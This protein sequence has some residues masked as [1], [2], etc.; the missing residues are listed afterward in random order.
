M[1]LTTLLVHKQSMPVK[2]LIPL[3]LSICWTSFNYQATLKLGGSAS[4]KSTSTF[5]LDK[6]D[7]PYITAYANHV[8]FHLN[9]H[10]GH[11]Q[12]FMVYIRVT[13][14]LANKTSLTTEPPILPKWSVRSWP[15]M[16]GG[17]WLN[18]TTTQQ[19]Y[20]IV[21]QKRRLF[22]ITENSKYQPFAAKVLGDG[23]TNIVG[24]F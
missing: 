8:S 18:T 20:L 2:P 21:K 11:T 15:M 12:S 22:S 1:P 17:A 23:T 16:Y 5:L 10:R 3:K 14:L 19:S 24:P 6:V 7:E 4:K 9:Y 13:S